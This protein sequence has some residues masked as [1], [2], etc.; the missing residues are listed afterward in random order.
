MR[1]SRKERLF[2]AWSGLA[3]VSPWMIQTDQQKLP[4]MSSQNRAC[5]WYVL[6]TSESASCHDTKMRLE[7]ALLDEVGQESG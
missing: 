5:R 4:S 7:T 2:D 3:H 1:G 6:R